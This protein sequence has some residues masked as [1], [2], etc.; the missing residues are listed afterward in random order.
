MSIWKIVITVA[1]AP[2]LVS[3][4]LWAITPWPA[5]VILLDAARLFGLVLWPLAVLLSPVLFRKYLIEALAKIDE[6]AGVFKYTD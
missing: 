5:G 4:I 2:W 3:A 6:H 1:A